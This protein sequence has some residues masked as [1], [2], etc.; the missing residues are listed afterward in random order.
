MMSE[1]FLNALKFEEYTLKKNFVRYNGGYNFVPAKI[2][3]TFLQKK[4]VRYNEVRYNGI[5]LV[6]S[7]VL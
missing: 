5:C 7:R 3:W 4:N 6:F 1:L 2:L